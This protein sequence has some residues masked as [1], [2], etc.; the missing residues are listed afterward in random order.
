VLLVETGAGAARSTA[1]LLRAMGCQVIG[2]PDA[3]SAL[4]V[5]A[6]GIP[7]DLLLTDLLLPG[8]HGASLAARLRASDP[9]LQVIFMA[10][11]NTNIA[12]ALPLRLLCKPLSRSA[13][14]AAI[15]AALSDRGEAE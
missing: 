2:V 7:V 15:T 14:A 8:E 13:L 12:P 9:R 1:M 10:E 4:S 6:R 3:M 5:V 11:E